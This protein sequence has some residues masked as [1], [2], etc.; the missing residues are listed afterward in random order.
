MTPA[1][2]NIYVLKPGNLATER[3][4]LE[5]TERELRREGHLNSRNKP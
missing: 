5:E 1:A 2:W 4:A 3:E